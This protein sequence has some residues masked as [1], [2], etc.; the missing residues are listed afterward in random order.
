MR[1]Y[2]RRRLTSELA[3]VLDRAVQ[4]AV[5]RQAREELVA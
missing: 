3:R 1:P 2:E 4:S 5:G